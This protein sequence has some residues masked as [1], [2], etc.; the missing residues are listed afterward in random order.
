VNVNRN[1]N[2]W[3][4]NWWFVGVRN[5]LS[6]RTPALLRAF[7]FSY[8]LPVPASKLFASILKGHRECRVLVRFKR[9]GFPQNQNRK[10]VRDCYKPDAVQT[11]SNRCAPPE[12]YGGHSDW[13]SE[14]SLT[15]YCLPVPDPHVHHGRPIEKCVSP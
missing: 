14:I 2:D 7:G 8:N 13:A 15:I 6:L 10:R 1:D 4:D 12:I 11:G 9:S 5:Y 3:N